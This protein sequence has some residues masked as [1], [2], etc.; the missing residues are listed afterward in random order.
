VSR[1][2]DLQESTQALFCA[3]ADYLGDQEAAVAFDTNKYKT[4]DEFL[5]NYISKS[6]KNINLIIQEAYEDMSDVTQGGI[7][8]P[9]M[10]RFIRNDKSWWRSSAKIS[11]GVI[12]QVNTIRRK[13][14]KIKKTKWQDL[15]YKRGDKEI[16][17]NMTKLFDRANKELKKAKVP[18]EEHFRNINKWS[19]ADIYFASENAEKRVAKA[20]ADKKNYRNFHQINKLISDLIDSG[21]LV[22]ISLKKGTGDIH[23]TKVNFSAKDERERLSKFYC[24]YAKEGLDVES[25]YVTVGIG[26]PTSTLLFRF[27]IDTNKNNGQYKCA[28][29][30]GGGGFGGS[31]GG[32]SLA[33]VI[34][35]VDPTFGKKF[36][37]AFEKGMDE[38]NTDKKELMQIKSA[39]SRVKAQKA[40]GKRVV[41]NP[42]NDLVLA[43]FKGSS[44]KRD[45]MVREI[46]RYA[47]SAS[48][49]SA[50]HVIAK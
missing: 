34:E 20:V 10:E 38:W 50:K 4:Y 46:A 5:E 37:T 15:Y 11:L 27:S 45:D 28:I 19:P 36:R 7:T 39:T 18:D 9:M 29:K 43:Y 21:D 48:K 41:G 44:K 49:L 12:E 2:S 3:V 1:T 13:F 35:R 30:L 31:V 40:L 32:D 16:M 14:S 42:L 47:G 23:V 6:G 17:R 25:A 26:D 22:P 33:K 24:D 8:L